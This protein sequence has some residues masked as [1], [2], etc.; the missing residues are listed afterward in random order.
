MNIFLCLLAS[1]LVFIGILYFLIGWNTSGR[2]IRCYRLGDLVGVIVWYGMFL[3]VILLSSGF[4]YL[5]AKMM[6]VSVI[7]VLSVE[8][9]QYI[10]FVGPMSSVRKRRIARLRKKWEGELRFIEV[11]NKTL[12][13]EAQIM[14]D[15]TPSSRD[16]NSRQNAWVRKQNRE[17][18]QY[19]SEKLRIVR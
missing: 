1:W 19:L 3:A 16:Q 13:I 17:R 2:I 5:G 18:K 11:Q 7:F 12:D 8:I 6:V 15:L 14:A 10:W 4:S 9:S